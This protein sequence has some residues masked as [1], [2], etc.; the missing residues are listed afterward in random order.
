ML[1]NRSLTDGNKGIISD[2]TDG[3]L[4]VIKLIGNYSYDD[5]IHKVSNIYLN[6]KN[7]IRELY[8]FFIS[9]YI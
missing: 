3:G 5:I 8:S 7:E 2:L 1:I 4:E 6:S 9:N